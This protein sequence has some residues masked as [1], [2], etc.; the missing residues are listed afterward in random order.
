[1]T[2][3]GLQ[4]VPYFSSYH[5]LQCL[6][7]YSEHIRTSFLSSCTYNNICYNKGSGLCRSS[8]L[9]ALYHNGHT[10]AISKSNLNL[11]S[12]LKNYPVEISFYQPIWQAKQWTSGLG[13]SGISHRSP[14]SRTSS[15]N[16]TINAELA[17]AENVQR[18]SRYSK[19]R[20]LGGGQI[21]QW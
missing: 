1:M 15:R 5:H 4:Y 3:G 9:L 7:L 17:Q 2:L 10:L 13:T 14:R 6:F 19:D 11:I 20:R 21:P 8:A 12:N 16:G 18:L